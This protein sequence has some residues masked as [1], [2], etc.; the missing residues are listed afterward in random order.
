M[1]FHSAGSVCLSGLEKE[2]FRIEDSQWIKTFL[3]RN[4]MHVCLFV[5]NSEVCSI[6]I[7]AMLTYLEVGLMGHSVIE[8][9][10]NIHRTALLYELPFHQLLN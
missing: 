7:S 6:G 10:V 5:L 1:P 8:F 3:Q 4:L 2:R 9:Q